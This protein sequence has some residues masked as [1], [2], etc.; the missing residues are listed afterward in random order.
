VLVGSCFGART[1]LSGGPSLAGLRGLVLLAPPLRDFALSEPKMSAWRPRDYAALALHPRRLLGAKERVTPRRYLRFVRSGTRV[2]LR[3]LRNR[4]AR[5]AGE[6]AW[7]SRRFLDPLSSLAKQGIPVLLLYGTE[8]DEYR[9]F[10]LARAGRLGE[11][12][13]RWPTVEVRTL[14]G[15]VHGFTQL[16]S[17]EATMDV[18]VDWIGRMAPSAR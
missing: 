14:V 7:V 3:R 11:I 13:T 12:M 1:A 16:D 8:D 10:E 15:Q 17:Q 9:D 6:L 4:L 18:V 2:I 5:K